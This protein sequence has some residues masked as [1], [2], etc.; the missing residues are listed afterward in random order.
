MLH[1]QAPR[2]VARTGLVVVQFTQRRGVKAEP[3]F[4][5][6][7]VELLLRLLHI[8]FHSHEAVHLGVDVGLYG[9][10]IEAD[11]TIGQ[12]RVDRLGTQVLL[13]RIGDGWAEDPLDH[14]LAALPLAEYDGS[15]EERR[16]QDGT[17]LQRAHSS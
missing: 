12:D 3:G 17:L 7:L 10:H 4:H 2:I 6:T 1:V 13:L 11:R 8:E 15:G 14:I 9:K 5:I 16:E